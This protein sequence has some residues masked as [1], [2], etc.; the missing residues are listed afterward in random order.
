MPKRVKSDAPSTTDPCKLYMMYI[1][2]HLHEHTR[3]ILDEMMHAREAANDYAAN[4]DR[5]SY[6]MAERHVRNCAR[7]LKKLGGG[8]NGAGGS[9]AQQLA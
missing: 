8:V 5:L 2:V 1:L 4:L 6:V 9:A 3:E 7:R